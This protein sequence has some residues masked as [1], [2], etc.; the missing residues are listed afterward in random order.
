MKVNGKTVR[1]H[2]YICKLAHGTPPTA[3]HH[4]A[5]SCGKGHEGC[6]SPN[7]LSWKTRTENEADK[8][9]HG[10][11][12]RGERNGNANLTESDVREIIA[13]KGTVPQRKIAAMFGV[14]RGAINSIYTGKSW[15]W[16]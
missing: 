1:A 6:V 7:H 5:H 11:R 15:A 16:L 12:S 13:I 10:T 4:S 2:R 9:E 8:L 3:E 14:T